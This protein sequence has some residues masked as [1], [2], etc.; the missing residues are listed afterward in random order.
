MYRRM[1]IV[2]L[3]L[4]L[5]FLMSFVCIQPAS[6]ASYNAS[7]DVNTTYQTLEGFGAAIA[8]YDSWLANHP[9][10]A[11]I[12]KVLFGDSGLDILRLRNQYQHS[13][14]D[15]TIDAQIFNAGKQQNPAL[16]LLLCSWSP[17]STLKKNGTMNGGTLAKD[18]S[19]FVYSKFGDYWYDSLVAYA[20]KGLVPDY[21]S[22][23]NEPDYE[24]SGW[25]TCILKPTEDSNYPS[26]GKALDAVYSKIQNMANKPK[27]LAPE[28]AGIDSSN[29][30]NYANGMDMSKIY[31]IAHHLYNG[32]DGN[33]PDSFN[34]IFK[35][36]KAAYPNKPLF[37]T[38]YD[39]GTAFTTAQLIYNSLVNEGVSGYFYW[40]LIWTNDQRP[41]VHLDDPNNPNGWSNPKGYSV[42]D[43]YYTMQHFA[44][45]TDPGYKRVSASCTSSDIP[46]T[47]FVSPDKKK[48]TLIL[49]NKG[50]SSNTV[51]LNVNGFTAASTAVYQTAGND[52][53]ASKGSLSG[54]TVTLPAQS[55]VTVA[56]DAGVS[57][58]KGDLNGDGDVDALDLALYKQC[59]LKIV[60]ETTIANYQSVMDMNNDNSRDALDFALIKMYL[61]NR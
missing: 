61:I 35:A 11:E 48:L 52:K 53:F 8:W 5:V 26:Y 3:I 29:V 12:Y 39:Y 14:D 36:L 46:I 38:E 32:G 23:Q 44:K 7:V 59:L 37:Q 33:N 60:D 18:S 56:M 43:F 2:T 17:P 6:A 25:E 20:A 49:I 54:N 22:I 28:V 30:Q 40:D 16:K 57:V 21:I 19:G 50:S 58:K 55:I 41:L 15:S 45:F 51:T 13:G 47:G 34:N 24:N 27:I 9:N 4:S 31:G 1:R 10:K 42:T